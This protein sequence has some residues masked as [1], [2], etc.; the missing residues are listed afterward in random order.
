VDQVSYTFIE[1]T[2]FIEAGPLGRHLISMVDAGEPAFQERSDLGC[3]F[4]VRGA[5]GDMLMVDV[6]SA[7]GMVIDSLVL[8]SVRYARS[9]H[10]YLTCP[11]TMKRKRKLYLASG[12]FASPEA[13][14]LRY[15]SRHQHPEASL[16]DRVQRLRR[17]LDGDEHRGPARRG[18]RRNLIRQMAKAP[19]HL[20]TDKDRKRIAHLRWEQM[21]APWVTTLRALAVGRNYEWEWPYRVPRLLQL[22]TQAIRPARA[23]RQRRRRALKADVIIDLAALPWPEGHQDAPA[24]VCVL[25]YELLGYFVVQLQANAIIVAWVAGEVSSAQRLDTTGEPPAQLAICPL[26][27]CATSLLAFRDGFLGSP[28][29]Q[30]LSMPG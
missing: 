14:Q 24:G 2:S 7:S 6:L 9:T 23:P 20:L 3:T 21:E 11:L 12:K 4:R 30:G 5:K 16:G 10:W 1:D 27:G 19:E 29:G 17:K 22:A 28:A 25:D 13:H 18:N 15:R 8:T 26:T